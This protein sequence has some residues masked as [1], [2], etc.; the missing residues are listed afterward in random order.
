MGS[1]SSTAPHRHN[2]SYF[3]WN[4][5]LLT[6]GENDFIGCKD[7]ED[8]EINFIQLQSDLHEEK[9]EK[10]SAA[11]AAI[12][13]CKRFASQSDKTTLERLLL[14]LLLLKFS[15]ISC[16]DFT[17]VSLKWGRK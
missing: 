5:C 15:S 1:S 16:L 13:S 3:H 17:L 12:I 6:A 8:K 11:D 9:H 4:V 2:A 14:V 7:E 10:Q